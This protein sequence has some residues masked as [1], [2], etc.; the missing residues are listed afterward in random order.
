MHGRE[1]RP[2]SS[3]ATYFAKGVVFLYFFVLSVATGHA[4]MG[5]NPVDCF[6]GPRLEGPS[7]GVRDGSASSPERQCAAVPHGSLADP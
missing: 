7:V 4:R 6:L 3:I 5:T 2:I 1:L